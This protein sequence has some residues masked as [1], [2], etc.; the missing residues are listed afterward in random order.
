MFKGTLKNPFVDRVTT[1]SGSIFI[2][3]QRKSPRSNKYN[4]HS[5]GY[6]LSQGSGSFT[7]EIDHLRQGVSVINDLY[8]A[9]S[10]LPTFDFGVPE[11]VASGSRSSQPTSGIEEKFAIGQT[12]T[13]RTEGPFIDKVNLENIGATEGLLAFAQGKISTAS[14]YTLDYAIIQPDKRYHIGD[15]LNGT[16]DTFDRTYKAYTPKILSRSLAPIERDPY[17]GISGDIMGGN[18]AYKKGTDQILPVIPLQMQATSSAP[19]LDRLAKM[20][21]IKIPDR[22]HAIGKTS[23]LRKQYEP[24]PFDDSKFASRMF[25][26]KSLV[27]L[28]NDF[29]FA[30]VENVSGSTERMIPEGFKSSRT[31]FIFTNN[32][33]NLDSIAFGG[34][35]RDA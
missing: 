30:I 26:E 12:K 32:G 34:M 20:G 5:A 3:D 1:S 22:Q 23:K 9:R 28:S 24:V 6:V 27:N 2:F 14:F 11:I 10:V 35:K 19:F 15:L 18:P 29:F 31:G 33:V 21:G 13:Y 8:K 25:T 17:A 7:A 16:I 4:P